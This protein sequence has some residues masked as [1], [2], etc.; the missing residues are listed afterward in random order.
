MVLENRHKSEDFSS[1]HFQNTL[2]EYEIT[3]LPY[4]SGQ[5]VMEL[6]VRWRL[7]HYE[8]YDPTLG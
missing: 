1:F 5:L 2:V 4:P 7:S 6:G 3:V 8:C